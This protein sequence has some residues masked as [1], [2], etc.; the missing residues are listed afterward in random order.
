MDIKNKYGV[1]SDFFASGYSDNNYRML[2]R[3]TDDISLDFMRGIEQGKIKVDD[4]LTCHS[5]APELDRWVAEN[6]F[7]LAQL[8][9]DIQSHILSVV[10][11]ALPAHDER[12]I[13][14]K[15]AAE[16]LRFYQMEQPQGYKSTFV[17]PM[18]SHDIGRLLEG[19]LY[20][21]QAN[22]HENW[23]S[24]SH[25][26]FLLLKKILD[27]PCYTEMPQSLKEHFLY[28]VLAHS[29]D[30]GK[31]YMSRAVQTCDRMQLIGAE[32]LYR[33][34]SYGVCL[35]GADIKYPD[36]SSYQYSLPDMY[37]HTSVLSALEYCSR[38]MR[39]NIGNVHESWQRRI[40]VENIILL[41]AACEKNEALASYLFAPELR[42][43]CVFGPKKRKM[44]EDILKEAD[45]LF[46]R[47]QRCSSAICSPFEV[48][49]AAII[50]IEVPLGAAKLSD[51]MKKSIRDAVAAMSDIERKSLFQM[52]HIAD[53]FRAEQDE[54]DRDV[55]HNSEADPKAYIRAIAV[56]TRKYTG[57][58]SIAEPRANW[59]SSNPQDYGLAIY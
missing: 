43:D 14:F 3:L 11:F 18:F 47:L 10:D 37:D 8:V 44:D 55:S 58:S 34:L 31:S 32:G 28:A 6:D 22:P 38:N 56:A 46:N 50:A 23:I 59:I 15:D 30:N 1:W 52:M 29:G 9:R 12:Q 57:L 25:L 33:S 7:L 13:L 26:S 45:Y 49:S 27:Q 40:A 41:K 17:I 2:R 24:H 39:E 51:D 35:M 19:R 4:G 16:G 5:S 20:D 53:Q 48:A 36:D 21:P 42:V 54:I